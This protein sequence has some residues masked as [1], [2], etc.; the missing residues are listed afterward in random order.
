MTIILLAP[1]C[2][3]RV[4]EDE[5][6]ALARPYAYAED[7]VARLAEAQLGGEREDVTGAG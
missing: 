5:R 7:A 6:D 2:F 4:L 1:W 3:V